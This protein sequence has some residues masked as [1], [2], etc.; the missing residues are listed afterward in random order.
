MQCNICVHN[1]KR[2]LLTLEC[3][4]GLVVRSKAN[5]NCPASIFRQQNIEVPSHIPKRVSRQ[6][7]IARMQHIEKC[8]N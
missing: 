4:L 2:L 1:L 5:W 7:E 6:R 8:S 3:L